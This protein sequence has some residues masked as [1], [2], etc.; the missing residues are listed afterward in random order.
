MTRGT[1]RLTANKASGVE[2]FAL[3]DDDDVE[4]IGDFVATEDLSNQSFHSVSLNRSSELL[5][6]RDPQSSHSA[7]G[8]QHEHG[9]VA[10]MDAGAPL[11]HLLEL[12]AAADSFVGAKAHRTSASSLG[13][14]LNAVP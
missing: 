2:P 6:C 5:G 1:E 3:R 4:S 12:S 10:A 11:V 7:I 9:A 8:R 13:A 14:Q